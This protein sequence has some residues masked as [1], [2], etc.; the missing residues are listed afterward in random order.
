[1][2]RSKEEEPG[3][4]ERPGPGPRHNT[5]PTTEEDAGMVGGSEAVPGPAR[6]D[7]SDEE[8]SN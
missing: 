4:D 1:M 5:D 8:E 2:E 3:S 6:D 7:D